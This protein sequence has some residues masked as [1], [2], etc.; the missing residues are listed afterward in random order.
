MNREEII[1]TYFKLSDETQHHTGT[2]KRKRGK[3]FEH[4]LWNLLE[5]EGLEP[6]GSFRPIGEEMDGSFVFNQQTYLIEAKWEAKPLSASSIYQFKGKVDGKLVGTIGV[7]ISMSGYSKECVDA[8]MYGKSLNIIL[9]DKADFEKCLLNINGFTSGLQDKLRAAAQS[10]VSFFPLTSVVIAEEIKNVDT[11][12]K[13]L[14]KLVIVVGGQGDQQIISFLARKILELHKIEREIV[15]R[16]AGGKLS[17]AALVN[18][19]D[20]FSDG[21]IQDFILVADSDGEI[22]ETERVLSSML[23]ENLTPII[24]VPDPEI[25]VWFQEFKIYDRNDM[26]G[27]ATSHKVSAGRTRDYLL[28]RLDIDYLRNRDASFRKFHNAILGLS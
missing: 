1:K 5:I 23:N 11:A 18:A 9:F 16:T 17:I 19:F 10:G 24:I 14:C 21:E 20:D 2:E 6:K 3:K 26:I 15:I 12:Q 4:L 25:E 22:E 27:H 28:H 8:L 13:P 7:F